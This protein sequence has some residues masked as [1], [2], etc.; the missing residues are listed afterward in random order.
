MAITLCSYNIDAA[1]LCRASTSLYDSKA[2]D[3][4]RCLQ[5][6]TRLVRF[7]PIDQQPHPFTFGTR[8]RSASSAPG[9]IPGCAWH[10]FSYCCR[11]LPLNFIDPYKGSQTGI[12]VASIS[13]VLVGPRAAFIPL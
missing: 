2:V 8:L 12:M 4:G 6:E 11:A 3:N 9:I 13:K 1:Y 5:A 7:H 10:D